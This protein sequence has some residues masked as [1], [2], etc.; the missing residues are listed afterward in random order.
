MRRAYLHATV[1]CLALTNAG[2]AQTPAMVIKPT[3]TDYYDNFT[4]TPDGST[5]VGVGR[6]AIK[7]YDLATGKE[8]PSEYARP[9]N[10]FQ[11][12]IAFTPD[13][14]VIAISGWGGPDVNL[15]KFPK[16]D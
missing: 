12:K 9:V 6:N 4:V 5:L 7:Y 11:T 2:F 14:K 13:G 10:T 16:K 8:S 1:L 15:Y 3:D